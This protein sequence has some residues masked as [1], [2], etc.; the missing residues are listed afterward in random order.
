MVDKKYEYFYDNG[1]NTIFQILSIVDDAFSWVAVA[2]DKDNI[3]Q[4]SW[5]GAYR[6]LFTSKSIVFGDLETLKVLYVKK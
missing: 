5:S 1:N 6:K 3:G 4:S 2:G